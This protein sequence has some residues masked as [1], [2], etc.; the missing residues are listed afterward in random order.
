MISREPIIKVGVLE[1]QKEINGVLNG[2][3]ALNDS[4]SI[5][6]PFNVRRDQ[7]GI[8]FSAAGVFKIVKQAE[9]VCKPLDASSFV[10]KDVQIGIQFHWERKEDQSFAGSL[11]IVSDGDGT[12]A[13]I[14][15]I[16]LEEY[17]KSVIS[18]E[19]SATAPFELL[20]A[21]A[22][23]SRSWLLA[24]LQ[25]GQKKARIPRQALSEPEGEIIRWYDRE[26]HKH[27]DVC[28]DDHCQRYQGISKIVSPAV[29]EAINTTRGIFLVSG[30]EICDAR[31]SKAC[32]GLT[33]SYE[34][35][36]E[37]KS[38]PYLT[39]ISDSQDQHPPLKTEGDAQKWIL[40][41]AEAYCHTTDGK[42][43]KQVLPSF[44]QE[45]TDFF[46]WKV[47]YTRKELEDLVKKRSGYDFGTIMNVRP[48][49]RGS[50]GR[51]SALK[52]EGTM[53]TLTVGKELEIRR[54]LSPSHLYSSAFVV[55]TEIGDDGIPK[56]FVFHGAGWGHGVGLCQI[57]AAVMATK[58][59]TAEEIVKH[60]FRDAE[61][62]KLY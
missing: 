29:A 26:S 50:S 41:A 6:G 8:A 17:L 27:F 42:I 1:H 7:T 47:E 13:A 33:E 38:V 10:L 25:G 35:V 55:G 12:L 54:W 4:V 60:Y 3:F 20:K 28:A 18:S 46:R 51:I 37:E 5:E 11:N 23:T 16:A 44:D 53:K 61:L 40:G 9:I 49:R 56:R 30:E 22:I 36:W 2:R 59:F 31:Y 34:N 32:G 57:G 19:M 43:L 62:Q 15:E 45:T 21:H 58:G 52:I 14:N 24:A 48:M 39:T